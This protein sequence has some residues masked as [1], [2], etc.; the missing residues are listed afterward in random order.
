MDRSRRALQVVT[1]ILGVIP[2]STGLVGLLGLRDP[3]YVRFGV[4]PNVALDSNLRFFGGVWLGLG[5]V[6][7][8][9]L[10]RIEREGALFR[11]MWG[12]IFLG[13]VGRLVSIV[14]AGLPP[15]PFLG[16]LVLEIVGAPLFVLWHRRIER[17]AASEDRPR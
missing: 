17:R 3:L 14:D 7:F 12:M 2:V 11:A 9:M 10:P 4:V 8:L 5:V 1:G 15:A 16:V 13:G 6:L